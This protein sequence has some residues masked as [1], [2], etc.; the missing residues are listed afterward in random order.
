MMK[1]SVKPHKLGTQIARILIFLVL[2]AL[3]LWFSGMAK[4]ETA[5]SGEGPRVYENLFEYR[6]CD[7]RDPNWC[8]NGDDFKTVLFQNACYYMCVCR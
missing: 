2:S 7:A 6:M 5:V 4:A 1:Q 8:P 3:G